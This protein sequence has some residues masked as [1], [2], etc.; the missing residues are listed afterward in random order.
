MRQFC[1]FGVCAES[2]IWISEKRVD[3]ANTATNDN[4]DNNNNNDNDTNNIT[5]LLFTDIYI[6]YICY[7]SHRPIYF[8]CFAV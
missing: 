7:F 4:N 2:I 3:Y 1:H 5:T 6:I 8:S